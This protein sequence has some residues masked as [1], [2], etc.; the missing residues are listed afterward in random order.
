MSNGFSCLQV[1]ILLCV[2]KNIFIYSGLGSHHYHMGRELYESLP[3][4]RKRF[5]ELADVA[6]YLSGRSIVKQI[7]DPSRKPYESFHATAVAG[8][9]IFAL[10]CALTEVLVLEGL[11]PDVVMGCSLGMFAASV[12][13]GS[14]RA[15]DALKVIFDQANTID[16]YGEEGAMIAVVG[17]VTAVREDSI[18][19][20]HAEI[21]AI[22]TDNSF[23]LAAPSVN[24]EVIEAALTRRRL[25]Y[26]RL[27]ITRAFHSRWIDGLHDLFLH[28]LKRITTCPGGIPVVCCSV[29]GQYVEVAPETLWNA[30]RQPVRFKSAIEHLEEAGPWRYIDAGPSGTLSNC[31]KYL[32][33]MNSASKISPVMTPWGGDVLR[34]KNLLNEATFL[35]GWCGV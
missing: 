35:G 17:S 26:Q 4:F 23:V 10:E 14:M 13:C 1:L 5:D 27:A 32:L 29:P 7:Y 16:R 25:T 19:C 30:V 24:L 34:F 33:P 21:A 6:G 28:N 15:E 31:L 12:A 8:L 20:T 3:L 9:A 11:K 22:N 2:V 18:L